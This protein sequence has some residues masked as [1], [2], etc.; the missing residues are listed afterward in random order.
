MMHSKRGAIALMITLFFIIAI[1]VS[2]GIALKQ[3]K[4][5]STEVS[6]Q[7][8]AMQSSV[9]VDD[10]LNLLKSSPELDAIDSVDSLF[11]F[12]SEAAFI[13]FESSGVKMLIEIK[14]ARSKLNINTLVDVNGSK[15]VPNS[16]RVNALSQYMA[17]YNVNPSYTDM[18]VDSMSKIKADNSYYSDI[19]NENPY[20]FRDYIAS[21]KHL[22]AINN[23][24]AKTYNEN[25]LQKINFENLFSFSKE[26]NSKVDLNYATKETW[27]LLLGC[28]EL[29]AE[30]LSLGAGAYSTEADLGLSPQEVLALHRFSVE[31]FQMFL[32]VKVTIESGDLSS[33]LRFEYDMNQKKGSN[34]VYEI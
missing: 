18:I 26:R 9:I 31:Y 15:A 30:Q 11:I 5:V 33:E 21:R 14:S 23:F 20:L 22:E 17:L 8:F 12:L 34:F 29:R 3:V 13:P 27:R 1:S 16:P 4:S 32:D 19:F 28:D 7:K 25:S 10:V 6:K 2:L 24:Y